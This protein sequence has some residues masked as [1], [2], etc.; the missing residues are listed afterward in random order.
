M[1]MDQV[2]NKSSVRIW[3]QLELGWQYGGGEGGGEGG[4]SQRIQDIQENVMMYNIQ[5]LKESRV[6]KKTVGFMICTTV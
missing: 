5:G 6:S 2:G 1:Q 3:Q 4:R